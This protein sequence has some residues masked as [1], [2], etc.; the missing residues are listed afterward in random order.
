MSQN[1]TDQL[2]NNHFEPRWPVVLAILAVLILLSGL[3]GRI[4]LFPAWFPYIAG[5]AVLMPIVVVSLVPAKEH[6]LRI[7]RAVTLLFCL[8]SG[9]AT[10]ANLVSLINAML[11]RSSEIS[12]LQLLA[13][14]VAV[15]ITNVLMFSLLY[16]QI[17]RGGPDARAN[18]ACPL[19]DWLFPQEGAPAEDLPPGWRPAFVDYFFLGF[20]TAAAFSPTDALPLTPRAKMLMM[21]QSTISLVTIVVV[22]SRAINILGS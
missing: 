21:L 19:P 18:N 3:P 2:I 7:E 1:E 20:N 8:V 13:S 22:A 14:G 11:H 5:I 12:G 4:R 16:W 9:C 15:W 6:W 10:V 17:D